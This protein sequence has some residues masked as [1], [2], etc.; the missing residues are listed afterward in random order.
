MTDAIESVTC[1][2]TLLAKIF[3]IQVRRVQEFGASGVLPKTGKNR[4]PLVDSV[5]A[6]IAYV[7][8]RQ[9]KNPQDLNL[10]RARLTK[11]QADH[12]EIDLAKARGELI[13]AE[14]VAK[15]WA[16]MVL[17]SKARLS[18]I[19]TSAAPLV[20]AADSTPEV[21]RILQSQIEEALDE[22]SGSGIPDGYDDTMELDDGPMEAAAEAHG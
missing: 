15:T 2:A 6:Y 9:A 12:K 14:D 21:T 20:A 1:G 8:E 5:T 18:A 22:L 11:A 3:G 19:P 4:Y 10:E 16:D 13:P 17:A 7:K